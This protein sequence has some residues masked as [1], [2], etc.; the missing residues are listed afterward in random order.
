[1]T[2]Q[3]NSIEIVHMLR[4]K[5][6]LALS[7]LVFMLLLSQVMIQYTIHSSQDDSRVVNIAG[8]QRMLS[9]R[10]NKAA[11][12]LYISMDDEGRARYLNELGTS[13]ELW[14]QSHQ[15]LQNGDEELGLPGRNSAKIVGMYKEIESQYKTI[16]DAA[17]DIKRIALNPSYN[18]ENL[19]PAIRIIEINQAEF[20]KGMDAI[21]FQ[22]DLESKQKVTQISII[23]IVI[24]LGSLLILTLEVFLIFG[25]AQKQVKSAMEEVETSNENVENLFKTAPIAMLLIDGLDFSIIKLNHRAQEIFKVSQEDAVNQNFKKVFILKNGNVNELM[26]RLASESAIENAEVII[27][28]PDHLSRVVHLSSNLIKYDDKNTI[29]LDIADITRLKDAEKV[30]KKYATIDDLTG[31]LNKRSGMLLL[32]NVFDRV[33]SEEGNFS[34]CFMDVDELKVVNDN[35]GHVEGDFYIKTISKVIRN[36]VSIN[37]AVFRYGGDEIVLVL[38][39]CDRQ[40]AENVVSRILNNLDMESKKFQKPYKMRISY[41]IAVYGENPQVTPE[42]LL[43]GADNEMYKNKRTNK[44]SGS[45]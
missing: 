45:V 10:I 2:V 39:G 15:G 42:L 21:V 40:S 18:S 9:Q 22:Y 3:K 25:P 16:V 17:T 26:D 33:G 35:Y 11:F 30:L 7:I 5:Y 36:S 27:D 13:L 1:M 20:L 8:R 14:T 44:E 19:L 12:G 37:D 43:R 28:T 4:K 6:A 24:L 32:R 31:F 23:E 38:E 41:G 34:V 29:L